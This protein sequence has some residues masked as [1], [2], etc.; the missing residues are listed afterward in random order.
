M[1]RS[2]RFQGSEGQQ[3]ILDKHETRRG[4]G[5]RGLSHPIQRLH[6]GQQEGCDN[7]A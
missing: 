6:N 4:S 2:V 1:A 3:Q 7:G 5:G